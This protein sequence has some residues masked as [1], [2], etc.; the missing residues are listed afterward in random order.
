M[1][2]LDVEDDQ[3]RVGSANQLSAQGSTLL[4]APEAQR[5]APR[6]RLVCNCYLHKHRKVSLT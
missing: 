4:L 5:P 2:V 6:A 1:V 3:C